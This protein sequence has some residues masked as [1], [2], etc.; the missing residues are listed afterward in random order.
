LEVEG[1][2]WAI[3]AEMDADEAFA[4]LSAYIRKAVIA[5]VGITLLVSLLALMLSNH[6][7]RPILTLTEAA[8]MVSQGQT[9]TVV[10]VRTKDEL[11]ELGAAFNE[12]IRSLKS[13]GE[14]IQQKIHENEEL[15]LNILPQPVAARMKLGNTEKTSDV[16]ADVTVL[17][18]EV[19]GLSDSEDGS[20]PERAV[21]LFNELVTAFD[22]AADRLGVEKV[23]TI[24][25][26]YM[27][28]CGLSVVRPDHAYRMVDFAQELLRVVRRFNQEKETQLEIKIGINAGPVVGGIVGRHKFIY[29]LW[30][31]TVNVA[32]AIRPR[33]RGNT[34]RVTTGVHERL[35][36][37]REF[38]NLGEVDVRGKGAIPVWEV[39]A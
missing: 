9:D 11:E 20:R 28:V 23:K 18:A 19:E 35:A 30:G 2:R 4:P 12:M 17:F 31:D 5:T 25:N 34:I 1:K 27:A 39:K 10:N 32:R 16:F 24:G 8:R 29:D 21:E 14:I 15:L 38:E 26:S 6:L 7:V 33:D 37:Q 36:G 13:K 22:E 3:L